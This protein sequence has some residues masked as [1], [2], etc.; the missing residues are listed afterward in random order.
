MLVAAV[1]VG[2]EARGRGVLARGRG[3]SDS[4]HSL[5]AGEAVHFLVQAL[6]MDE[7]MAVVPIVRVDLFPSSSFAS[8]RVSIR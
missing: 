2:G 5:A 6:S 4:H 8:L 7:G 1:L 3:R